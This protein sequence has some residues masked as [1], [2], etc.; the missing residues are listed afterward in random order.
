MNSRNVSLV[1]QVSSLF[2]RSITPADFFNIERSTD[3]GP[4]GGGG[5]LYISI[6]FRGLSYSDL[7]SFLGVT[8]PQSVGTN[9]PVITLHD[10]QCAFDRNESADLT[11]RPRYLPPKKDDRY[12][13][14]NQNRQRSNQTRHPAW[15]RRWGFPTAPDDVASTEDPGMPDL[16][17]LK[18]FVAKMAD[19]SYVAGYFNSDEVPQQ[20]K[21]VGA[22]LPLFEPYDGGNSAGVINL[23]GSGIT[24]SDLLTGVNPD[25]DL[26]AA[27]PEILEAIDATR[28]ASGR[29]TT[30]QG[31]RLSAEERRALER[32]SV[33]VA[34][35]WL[36]DQGW[37]VD[38]VGLFRPYD[39]HCEKGSLELRVEIKGTTGDGSAVLLTPGEVRHAREHQNTALIVVSGIRLSRDGSGEVVASGGSLKVLNPW[40]LDKDGQL[41]A[42]G[43]SYELF[44]RG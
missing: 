39:L 24:L 31:I 43:Y 11:F 41:H 29:G 5:Q 4:S 8:P 12:R 34:T 14:A 6:S 33:G 26:A 13:I 3:A 28:R 30:G 23:E 32:H 38:D 35:V 16:T 40:K 25:K 37:K 20:L 22:L 10:V 21:A 18:V 19:E 15:T 27:S 9:R 44:D 1:D 17:Y 42:T 2:W 36:E 7:D